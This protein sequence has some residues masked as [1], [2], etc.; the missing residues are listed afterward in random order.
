MS[1]KERDRA[2][3]LAK[4]RGEGL[5]L[6]EAAGMLALSYRQVKRLYKRFR[7]RGVK[8]LVHGNVGR[9]SNRGRPE[10]ERRDV[11]ALVRE[12]YS[13]PAAAGPGQR[14]GPTLAAEHLWDDHGILLPVTTLKRWMQEGKLWTRRRRRRDQH[15]VRARREHFG[16]LLQI[17][18]SFHDWFEGRGP[19]ACLM[20]LIDDA[21]GKKLGRF[22]K[23]ETLWTAAALLRQWVERYGVPRAIYADRK[24]LYV[25]P[26]S[27]RQIERGR[28]ALSQ[29]GLMCAKLEIEVIAAKS[30]EAKGRVE[31][32]HGTNQ[33]RL[34][35]KMRLKGIVT[36]EAANAFLETS[37]L[38][39][40]NARY[41]VRAGSSVDF[42]TAFDPKLDLGGVFCQE[43]R[44]VLGKGWVVHYEKRLL[45]VLPTSEA[46]RYCSP[47][48]WLLVRESEDGTI[49]L[50]VRSREGRERD[51]AW[52]PVIVPL[53]QRGACVSASEPAIVEKTAGPKIINRPSAS[54]PWRRLN[55]S[56]ALAR[57][58][59]RE[60]RQ[61]LAQGESLS[62]LHPATQYRAVKPETQNQGTFLMV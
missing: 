59:E 43:R 49:R 5:K 55:H 26:G 30:P 28:E 37:Y 36:Y 50:I 44:R 56:E 11:L 23:E 48:V 13:G 47:G 24:T 32:S 40:H 58:A 35:K 60:R 52:E 42:H 17:D 10:A 16:E 19:R 45:H 20:T 61:A 7:E 2:A 12:F 22:G 34:V 53:S 29:F 33:D 54:H 21:T 62:V 41:A 4:V 31:R 38:P 15:H 57:I 39:A 14:F 8:G 25:A 51:L 1:V 3:V 9:R 46:R 6:G 18:G 27:R